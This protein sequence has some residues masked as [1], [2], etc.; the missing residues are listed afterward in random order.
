MFI[1]TDLTQAGSF[2]EEK[3]EFNDAETKCEL[4]NGEDKRKGCENNE[5]KLCLFWRASVITFRVMLWYFLSATEET[6]YSMPQFLM[7]TWESSSV[8]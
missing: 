6:I 5:Q 3:N 7:P 1:A 2:N 4:N 8:L